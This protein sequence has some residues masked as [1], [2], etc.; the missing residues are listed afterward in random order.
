MST[1]YELPALLGTAS[2]DWENRREEI[3]YFIEHGCG[4]KRMAR[5]YGISVTHMKRVLQDLGLRTLE[6][7][8]L[9]G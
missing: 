9:S 3:A 4:L 2:R 1:T 6:Q 5:H 7:K 8:R